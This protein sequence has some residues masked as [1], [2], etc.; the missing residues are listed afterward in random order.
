MERFIKGEREVRERCFSP[1]TGTDTAF[2]SSDC[3]AQSLSLA[4]AGNQLLATWAGMLMAIRSGSGAG[5]RRPITN[6][7]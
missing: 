3:S 6:C 5:S 2:T 1:M 4:L 7:S